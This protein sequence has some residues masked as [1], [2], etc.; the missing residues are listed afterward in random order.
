MSE[1]REERSK[2]L[3]GRRFGANGSQLRF[4]VQRELPGQLKRRS[5]TMSVQGNDNCQCPSP[6]LSVLHLARGK[7][8]FR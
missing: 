4:R 7:V 3:K 8:L 5:V 1:L 2:S 6:P